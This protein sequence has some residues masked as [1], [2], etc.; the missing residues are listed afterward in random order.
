MTIKLYND[1]HNGDVFYS[2]III[3]QF[4]KNDFDVKYYHRINPKILNDYP[5][6]YAGPT[7]PNIHIPRGAN[8][9]KENLINT[10]IGK[11]KAKF[12]KKDACSFRGYVPLADEIFQ[13]Y[14]IKYDHEEDLL[15]TV[16]FFDMDPYVPDNVINDL[17]TIRDCY[18]KIVLVC[19]ND[20]MSG[21][22]KNFDFDPVIERLAKEYPKVA[23]L[24]TNK[25]K[26]NHESI[27]RVPQI[28]GNIDC[29]LLLISY[30][31]ISCDIII[32]RASGPYCYTHTK[33]N[34]LD[35]TKTYISFSKY[36]SE[37]I[38][39]DNS[40]AKQVNT[41]Q[42]NLNVVYDLIETEIKKPIMY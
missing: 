9:Y 38:W 34:L 29:D 2:R 14:G 36:P 41:D 26:I 1:F 42:H 3:D 32:G 12:V 22:I 5:G 25:T 40:V 17:C 18:D 35:K 13:Y 39:Y 7:N 37:G 6:L 8:N 19:N 21:Q 23:F 31:S 30:I 33:K 11:E 4:L 16:K 15:P 20:C 28:T 24:M 27:I 10:W